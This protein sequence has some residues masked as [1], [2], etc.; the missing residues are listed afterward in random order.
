MNR[1]APS[2]VLLA[3]VILA[4]CGPMANTTVTQVLSPG[5]EALGQLGHVPAPTAPPATLVDETERATSTTDPDRPADQADAVEP[6]GTLVAHATTAEIAVH[7]AP[8]PTSPVIERFVNPTERGGPL[9]FQGLG[10]PVDGWLEVRVPVRPN[11]VTGWIRTADAELTRNPYRIELDVGRYELTIYRDDE[12]ILVTTVGIGTGSTPTPRGEF[13]L[14]ELLR[15]PD[16]TGVYGPYAYG[17][18]GFSNALTSF[19][20]GPGLIGIHG[21]NQPELLGGNVSHGCVRVDN[22]VIT[23][24]SEFLP[25]GT[26]VSIYD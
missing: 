17:L 26:P 24:M 7:T 13:Y 19:N 11:G 21:T 16:P 10:E 6:A 9:V 22:D 2:A 1:A 18:S 8:N 25:L 23:E 15:P 20:G 3:A 4:N 14:I 5:S 12:P